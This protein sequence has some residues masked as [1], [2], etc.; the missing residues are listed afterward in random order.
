MF[1]QVLIAIIAFVF[2]GLLGFVAVQ[3]RSIIKTIN[4][5][6]ITVD[7][8]VSVGE[9]SRDNIVVLRKVQRPIIRAL[10]SHSYALR[11]V[12]A[13]GSVT[14]ALEHISAAEDIL[15]DQAEQNC[16]EAMSVE[17]MVEA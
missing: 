15:N 1:E 13:N 2:T 9:T 6:V 12:G 7:S 14:K 11:E 16:T 5:L 3:F 4:G 8:L 17:R 10:R